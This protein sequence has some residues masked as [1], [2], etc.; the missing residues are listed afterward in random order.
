MGQSTGAYPQEGPNRFGAL[1][2]RLRHIVFQID[3][4]AFAQFDLFVL[5]VG[6]LHVSVGLWI[7]AARSCAIR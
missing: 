7:A 5:Q 1:L 2:V 4:F 6:H 3:G